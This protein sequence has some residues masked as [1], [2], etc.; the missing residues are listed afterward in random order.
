[1]R[2]LE[3]VN[4]SSLY[5]LLTLWQA[6]KGDFTRANTK[7]EDLNGELLALPEVDLQTHFT[8]IYAFRVPVI[9]KLQKQSWVEFEPTTSCSLVQMGWCLK[10]TEIIKWVPKT[11]K[12]EC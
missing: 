2:L 9:K 11:C 6:I 4:V 1:M 5:D 3:V 10:Q 7:Q 12:Y 8:L